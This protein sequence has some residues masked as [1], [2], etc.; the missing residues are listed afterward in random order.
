MRVLALD[1]TT[2]AGSAALVAGDRVVDERSGDGARTH[3]LRL[4]GEIIALAEAN[5]WPLSGIDLYAVASGPGSFTGLRIGIATIQGLAFVHGRRVVGVPALDALAYAGSRDLSGGA[6]VAAWMD[7]HRREVF[8]ALYQVT[9]APPFSRA[10]LTEVDGPTVGSPASTLARWRAL[11]AGLPRVFVGDGAIL[12]AA[13][14]AREATEAR[15]LPPPLLAGVIGQLAVARASES[16]D[17]AAVRPLYVRRPDAEIARDER[18]RGRALRPWVIEPLAHDDIGEVLAIEE[19]A[20][21]NPW[22]R[23]MY[24]AELENS[25]VSFCFLARDADRRAVGFCSFW[26]ILD[27]LHINNLAVLPAFRRT[28]IASALLEFVLQYGVTLGARR[29]TLEMRRSNESARL[30]YERF[31]F[32]AA[33]VRKDYYSKPVE[34][35]LVLWREDLPL[36]ARRP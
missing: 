25:G 19:A 24:L 34:D 27:E 35:A 9:G 13:D 28:G 11:A 10:R 33:G 30:L 29:A 1:T 36:P 5:Q 4:P 26:R 22:T 16:L 31:G 12:Y 32:A 6:L 14:I 20:F 21:T 2:R 7:A 15:A 18:L 17:P 3:A 8:A 23:A